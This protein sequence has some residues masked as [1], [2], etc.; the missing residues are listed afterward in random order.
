[1]SDQNEDRLIRFECTYP[2]EPPFVGYL[3]PS[4]ITGFYP[5]TLQ[6]GRITIHFDGMW[7]GADDSEDL[8]WA[9]KKALQDR[10]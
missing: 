2:N 4:A 6:K 10:F 5:D 9:L 8:R 3:K 7:I 1:M